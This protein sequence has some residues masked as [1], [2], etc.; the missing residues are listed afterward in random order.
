MLL[1]LLLR[2]SGGRPRCNDAE[3]EESRAAATTGLEATD[4]AA[5]F[6]LC[7]YGRNLR[8]VAEAQPKQTTDGLLVAAR[9]WHG[10]RHHPLEQ[11]RLMAG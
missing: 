5:S 2:E 7:A 10:Q 8:V 11:G 3:K 4:G 6:A 1:L 9:P